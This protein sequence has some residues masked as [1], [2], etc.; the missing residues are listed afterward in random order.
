M[1]HTVGDP[2]PNPTGIRSTKQAA[3]VPLGMEDA[4]I[5]GGFWLDRQ[6]ANGSTSIPDG[7]RRLR[8]S[9]A[10]RNFAVAAGDEAG[11]VIGPI[12]ADSDV[13]KWLEA[14]AW[15]YGRRPDEQLLARPARPDGPGGSRS[16]GGRIPRHRR[17]IRR[18]KRYGN[19]AHDHELYCAGHL[20]QAAVAQSRATGHEDLLEV[21]VKLADHLVTTFGAGTPEYVEGHPVVE[22]GLVELFRE[23]G[24]HSYLEL[25]ERFVEARGHGVL[26]KQDPRLDPAYF[27]DRVPVRD[28]ESPEGHAV[29]PC[30]SPPA[31]PTWRRRRRIASS[32]KPSPPSTPGWRRCRCA[33]EGLSYHPCSSHHLRHP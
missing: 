1:L 31:R 8:D 26:S 30:T 13:Y 19:P 15:E 28:T 21:A 9:G 20:F 10:L 14:A 6:V 3:L 17:P 23:T 22:M 16:A 25:A 5:T 24:E 7:L 2:V 12:F 33:G 4:R 27:S 11:D 32:S 18:A 29:A